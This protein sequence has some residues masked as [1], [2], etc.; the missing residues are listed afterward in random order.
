MRRAGAALRC[1]GPQ[2]GT[3]IA[4]DE[5]ANVLEAF[6]AL[7]PKSGE[8]AWRRVAAVAVRRFWP[9]LFGRLAIQ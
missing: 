7:V 4:Q 8:R 9:V 1:G 6:R 2:S 3:V 5:A